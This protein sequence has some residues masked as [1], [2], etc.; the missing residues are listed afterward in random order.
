MNLADVR[1]VVFCCTLINFGF[2]GFWGILMLLPHGWMRM[3]WLRPVSAERFDEIN[4]GGI[5][6]YKILI[7]MFNLAP[8]LALLIVA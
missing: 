5:I 6:A 1:N 2:L 7:L 3:L 8:Y 4:F